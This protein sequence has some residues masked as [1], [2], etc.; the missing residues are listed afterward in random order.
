M[1]KHWFQIVLGMVTGFAATLA[2]YYQVS[3][4]RY[5]QY[6]LEDKVIENSYRAEKLQMELEKFLNKK[7]AE[8]PQKLEGASLNEKFSKL[9]SKITAIEQ[10]TIGLRQA[11]NPSKPEEILTIARLTDE[12]NLIR[13][14]ISNLDNKL[15]NQQKGFQESV[16]REI[17]SSS[18][19][20]TLILIVIVPLVLNFLYTVWKDI[21]AEK[22]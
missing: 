4:N 11:I 7:I 17:K 8:A 1:K 3:E 20:T 15:S 16:L 9:E 21:K 2:F 14:D 19:S 6:K 13:K 18:D 22:K 10:Q 5:I 12:V